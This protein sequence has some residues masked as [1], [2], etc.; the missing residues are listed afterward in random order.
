MGESEKSLKEV[1][2]KHGA[3]LYYVSVGF[4]KEE[5]NRMGAEIVVEEIT[6]EFSKLMNYLKSEILKSAMTAP[7]HR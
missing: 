5:I 3:K 2:I 7:T 1:C 6:E 4:P